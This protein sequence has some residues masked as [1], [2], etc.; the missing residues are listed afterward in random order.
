MDKKPFIEIIN[1]LIIE[2]MDKIFSKGTDLY[3][4]YKL[5]FSDGLE[6]YYDCVLDK[7]LYVKTIIDS[8]KKIPLHDVYVP[9]NLVRK[10]KVIKTS[11]A[12]T[13]FEL[14]KHF[15][16]L[17]YAGAGK[18]TLVK[19]L[20]LDSI[21][22]G[23]TI[24][25]LIELRNLSYDGDLIQSLV[26][27]LKTYKLA[28]SDKLLHR[29]LE[30]GIFTIYFDGLDEME[31]TV[32]EKFSKDIQKF[33]DAY[34]TNNI[35]IISRPFQ[36]INSF[37]NFDQFNIESLS[38]AQAEE[39][40]NKI[41]YDKEIKN[42]FIKKL[43]NSLFT[44]HQSFASNPLLLTLMLM[45]FSQYAEIPEKV[46]VFY[47]QAFEVL[48][49]RHD[50]TKGHVFHRKTF[51]NLSMFDFEKIFAFFCF[52]TLHH[53]KISFTRENLHE[54]IGKSVNYFK[55]IS[56]NV[57][58][59]INDTIQSFCLICQEGFEYLFIHRSFQEYFCAKFICTQLKE[60]QIKAV[61]RSFFQDNQS[62]TLFKLIYDMRPPLL[63]EYFI[64]PEINRMITSLQE[65]DDTIE[66]I[67]NKFFD[68]YSFQINNPN[69]VGLGM[70]ITRETKNIDFIFLLSNVYDMKNIFDINNVEELLELKKKKITLEPYFDNETW[71]ELGSLEEDFPLIFE[72]YLVGLRSFLTEGIYSLR[73][74]IIQKI[75]SNEKSLDEILSKDLT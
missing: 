33:R 53:N 29:L 36:V 74:E 54:Y 1:K 19:Y 47:Q 63:E 51:C 17:G 39:L 20:F 16:I 58:D 30:K 6:K 44:K 73:D 2:N 25:L 69:Q 22:N 55:D 65:Y 38:L 68:S 27:Y 71:C 62:G 75:K 35:V 32:Q 41:D 64:L 10:E 45:T 5:T 67:R 8:N 26:S 66:F 37:E 59:F 23:E 56:T 28:V 61:L 43:K 49:Q 12:S 18:S 31:N 52:I 7:Y 46:H 48:Y 40:I 50:S 24:P 4:E 13:L 14:S 42:P 9:L 72:K 34:Y 21:K 70:N 60:K 57:E 15:L 11:N 3:T